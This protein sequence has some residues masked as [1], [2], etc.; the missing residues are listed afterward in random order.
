MFGEALRFPLAG[1]DGVKSVLIG[2]ILGLLGFL[3]IPVFFVQGYTVRVL[4]V[5]LEGGEDAP[6]FDEWG[7]LLVDGVKLFV[8]GIVYFL[9]PTL[10]MFISIFAF[11]GIASVSTAAAG[12]P[13]PSALAG[14]GIVGLLL[15]AVTVVLFILAAYIVPAAAT[16]FARHDDLGAAFDIRTV[17]DAAFTA[18]YFVAVVFAILVGLL[19]GILSVVLSLIIVGLILVP[20]LSFYAQVATYYLF[21]RGYAKGLNLDEGGGPAPTASATFE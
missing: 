8:I 13:N 16:N 15:F 4:R 14:A 7:D 10:L 5:A 17:I 1:D 21:A 12:D 19:L 9:L 2:G 11:V 18:D 20:F 6:A 3:V